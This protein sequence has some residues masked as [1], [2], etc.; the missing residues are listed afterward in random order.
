VR[1][2]REKGEGVVDGGHLEKLDVRDG[3]VGR[4]MPGAGEGN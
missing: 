1:G 4:V 2:D 3:E